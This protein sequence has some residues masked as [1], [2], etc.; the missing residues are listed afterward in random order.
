MFKIQFFFMINLS[1]N[2]KKIYLLFLFICFDIFDI[3]HIL[4]D[5]FV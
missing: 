3:R 5:I 4:F 1:Y 2:Y